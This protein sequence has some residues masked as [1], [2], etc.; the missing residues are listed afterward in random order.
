MKKRYSSHEVSLTHEQMIELRKS[1]KLNL[2]MENDLSIRLADSL[3]YSPKSMLSS[4][5]MHF[6]SCVAV[7]IFGYSIY[8]SITSA[9]WWFIPGFSIMIAIHRAN[10]KG[11]SQNLLYEAMR[12]KEFYEKV[13][14]I[15]GWMYEM[16]EE[17]ASNFLSNP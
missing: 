4:I 9:W 3:D 2:G 11:T 8:L 10:K 5:A 15:N 16:E 1:G 12:D 6:W 7:G 13:R 17:D 14:K